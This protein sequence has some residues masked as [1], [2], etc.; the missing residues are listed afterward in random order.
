MKRMTYL[1]TAMVFALTGI[2][3]TWAVEATPTTTPTPILT[4]T[5]TPAP[6]PV[7]SVTPPPT[8]NKGQTDIAN[9]LAK[10]QL[11]QYGITDPTQAQMDAALY[12]GTI[13]S[14]SST[15]TV[16]KTVTLQGV[17]TQ[18]AA[19]QGWGQIANGMGVKLGHVLS[20]EKSKQHAPLS[21]TK[22]AVGTDK[23]ASKSIARTDEKAR[24]ETK[25]SS[26]HITTAGDSRGGVYGREQGKA[27]V[28][29]AG[30]KLDSAQK[31]HGKRYGAG[32]VTAAGS[33]YVA[34]SHARHA[35]GA[36]VVTANA[37]SGGAGKS[38][39][40]DGAHGKSGK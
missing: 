39:A 6:A 37:S 7:T 5:L 10:A 23:K 19:G 26:K 33:S 30:G 36:G 3:P 32:I 35:T 29:T 8:L 27:S 24:H 40:A 34:T 15:G 13:T 38:G 2:V 14:V 25:H 18:R 16:S 17:L 12:G 31:E 9:S 28:T 22:V 1:S 20:A 4:P 11:A 21:D